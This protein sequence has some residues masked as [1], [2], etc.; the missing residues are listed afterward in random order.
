MLILW[1]RRNKTNKQNS[2]GNNDKESFQKH[3][4]DMK[5]FRHSH[6]KLEATISK[7]IIT[8]EGDVLA[9]VHTVMLA[10][11]SQN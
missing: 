1:I 2:P 7:D 5:R 6:Q 4:E 8:T 9:P 11:H 3:D 10:K